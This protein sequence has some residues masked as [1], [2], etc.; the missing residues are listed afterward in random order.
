MKICKWMP[1]LLCGLLIGAGTVSA[2][3]LTYL[4]YGDANEC[5]TSR[6]ILDRFEAK[7]PNISV[8][9]NKVGYSVIREQL[10][11]QL[12]A[13]E[14]PDLARVT[15]LGGLNKYYLDIASYVDI[16]YWESNY[17]ST[18]SWFRSGKGDNGIYGW[19][20]Q[21]TV[22]GPYINVTLF[23]DAGV[24]IPSQGAT[25]DDWADASRKVKNKLNLYAGMVMDR[26]GHRLAGPAM[27][28]GA[29]YFKSS[30]QP[31]VIDQGFKAMAERM[32]SWHKEGLM[33]EDIWPAASGAKWKNGG[34]MFINQD[35]AFHMSG[36]WMIQKY[37]SAIGDTF[38]WKAVPA[39]CGP[40]GCGAMPGGAGLV[41]FKQTKHPAAVAKV[42]DFFAA[43]AN[44]A[45]FY[46]K[47]LQ[48]PAHQGL[49]ASGV[50][51]GDVSPSVS[52]ALQIYGQNAASAAK[53]T[54]QAYQLQGYSKGFVIYNS[55]VNYISQACAGELTLNEAYTKIQQE[56]S[57]KLSE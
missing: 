14:G 17:G 28:M 38:E 18:L 12:E 16:K 33:P 13:G 8:K 29:K 51:Y 57:A 53:T 50:D 45:E 15:N 9:I 30:G 19:M 27:A 26:S 23:E 43:E 11:T 24:N 4:C 3:E 48:I 37:N 55:T 5:E 36:S 1:A 52:Q 2:I 47:S 41:G 49:Q 32:V 54:P 20:T 6:A 42:M 21:L 22:T 25:W 10:E 46:S 34:E 44:A 56:I 40:G 39:P 35:V 31:A 7:N